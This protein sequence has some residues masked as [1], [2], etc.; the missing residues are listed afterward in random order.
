MECRVKSS[1]LGSKPVRTIH[2]QMTEVIRRNS[3][4]AII[5]CVITLADGKANIQVAQ[6]MGFS[7]LGGEVKGADGEGLETPNSPCAQGRST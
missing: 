3:L 7:G 4:T 2:D 6:F 5:K 1:E